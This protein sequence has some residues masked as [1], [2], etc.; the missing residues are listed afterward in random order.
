MKTKAL[1]YQLNDHLRDL[2]TPGEQDPVS[3]ED[4][5]LKYSPLIKFV[6]HRLAMRLPTHISVQDLISAGVIGLMDAL[7]K[8]DPNKGVE[9]KTYAEFRI[10]GAMLDELR[11]MDWVPRSV[12]QKATRIERTILHLEN[13]MGRPVEDEEVAGELGIS[14]EDYYNSINEINGLPLLDREIFQNKVQS[15][16]AGLTT[17]SLREIHCPP[18]VL[19]KEIERLGTIQTSA[20]A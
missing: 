10:R 8:Y 13:K 19:R 2:D 18:A 14:L 9:F 11:A 4:M 1:K 7:S 17:Q 3:Q 12:R 5:V 15:R 16:T 20:P 6:A